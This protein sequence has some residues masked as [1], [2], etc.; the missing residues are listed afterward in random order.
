M[1]VFQKEGVD[2]F[3]IVTIASGLATIGFLWVQAIP[4]MA[5]RRQRIKSEEKQKQRDK[6][7][8]GF[9]MVRLQKT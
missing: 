7:Q 5:G 6:T 4:A 1:S 3:K 8:S 2:I 9:F